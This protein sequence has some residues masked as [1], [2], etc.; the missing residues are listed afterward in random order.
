MSWAKEKRWNTLRDEMEWSRSKIESI[1]FCNL[2]ATYLPAEEVH[3]FMSFYLDSDYEGEKDSR[4]YHRAKSARETVATICRIFRRPNVLYELLKLFGYKI[5]QE[6][7]KVII[8]GRH[9]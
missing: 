5:T 4:Y 8:D 7:D 3:V 6:G 9:V 1:E 2:L